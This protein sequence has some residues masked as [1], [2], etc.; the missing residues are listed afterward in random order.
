MSIEDVAKEVLKE[1][2][3]NKNFG[4]KVPK[5]G[6]GKK[7][8]SVEKGI[9]TSIRGAVDED[10]LLIMPTETELEEAYVGVIEKVNS[11][12]ESGGDYKIF[13]FI[14][15][16]SK[17]G[18]RIPVPGIIIYTDIPFGEFLNNYKETI[19]ELEN[20]YIGGEEY[21]EQTLIVSRV[22]NVQFHYQV[23]EKR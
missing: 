19:M 6:V 18:P 10:T 17:Q 11:I 15:L 12:L 3:T 23:W 13:C 21:N 16:N 5:K 7:P 20:K 4:L 1:R 9:Y 22:V 8:V 14:H 2:L